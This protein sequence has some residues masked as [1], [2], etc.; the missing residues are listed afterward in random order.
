M[1]RNLTKTYKKECF[2]FLDELR[3]SGE[4]NMFGAATYLVED[5]NLEKK[6]AVSC[7]QEWM[8]QHKEKETA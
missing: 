6:D 2:K 8:N 4:C 5:F 1:P 3:A 7:L